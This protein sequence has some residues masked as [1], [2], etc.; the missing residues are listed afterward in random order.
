MSL[1]HSF[2]FL[3]RKHLGSLLIFFLHSLAGKQ[4]SVLTHYYP[5]HQSIISSCPST[6]ISMWSCGTCSSPTLCCSSLQH[7]LRALPNSQS[8]LPT[9]KAQ[10]HNLAHSA[11]LIWHALPPILL[12]SLESSY[13]CFLTQFKLLQ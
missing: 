6:E 1:Y 9:H 11:Q 8:F 7:T 10:L 13:L 5:Q 12:F 2:A 3:S 4:K